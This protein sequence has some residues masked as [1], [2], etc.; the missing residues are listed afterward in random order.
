MASTGTQLALQPVTKKSKTVHFH[1]NKPSLVWFEKPNVFGTE[2]AI[3]MSCEEF[4]TESDD[5][6]RY[7]V[8]SLDE[9]RQQLCKQT[10]DED[11]IPTPGP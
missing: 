10:V 5:R 2:F 3:V 1:V 6:T 9:L 7:A 4:T 8:I 11:P